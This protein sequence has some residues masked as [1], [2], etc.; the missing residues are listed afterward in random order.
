MHHMKEIH[1]KLNRKFTVSNIFP[2]VVDE[3]K[4]SEAFGPLGF[5]SGGKTDKLISNDINTSL[6]SSNQKF[7]SEWLWHPHDPLL[8][9]P[10]TTST[11]SSPQS[12]AP[13]LELKLAITPMMPL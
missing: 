12:T 6:F 4:L 7:L 5:P 9:W 3:C 13:D 8:K 2:Q 1:S 10:S 11:N